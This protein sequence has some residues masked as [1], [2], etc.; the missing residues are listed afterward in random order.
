MLD[1]LSGYSNGLDPTKSA[2]V[3]QFAFAPAPVFEAGK[4]AGIMGAGV[5]GSTAFGVTATSPNAD[6]AWKFLT[7]LSS[8]AVQVKYSA[9]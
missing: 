8:E 5:D 6:A 1:W 2:I 4:A 7:Y 9:K 3:D